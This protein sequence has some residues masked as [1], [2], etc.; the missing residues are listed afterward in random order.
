MSLRGIEDLIATLGFSRQSQEMFNLDDQHFYIF[1]EGQP[2]LDYRRRL[3]AARLSSPADYQKELLLI[4]THK[5]Q[6]AMQQKKEEE[7]KKLKDLAKYDYMERKHMKVDDSK[8][9]EL[10]FGSNTKTCQDMGIGV[11][12]KGNKGSG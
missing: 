6:K 10:A 2:A 4:K 11:K 1:I 5:Q 12:G 8:S 7:A 3:V 9:R